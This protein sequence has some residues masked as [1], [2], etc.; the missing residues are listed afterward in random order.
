ML[1]NWLNGREAA[2]V[3]TALADEGLLEAGSD[4]RANGSPDGGRQRQALQSFLQRFLQKVDREARPLQLN[5]YKRAKLANTFKWR[6]L[7]KGIERPIVDELTQALVL[8]LTPVRAA[9]RSAQL[10]APSSAKAPP[11]GNI[12]TLLA[13][14]S[15]HM[16]RGAWARLFATLVAM[17][18]PRHSSVRPSRSI[19]S[20]P[21]GIPI[22]ARCCAGEAPL[23][24]QRRH[25]GAPSS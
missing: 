10:P 8:R 20:T 4:A 6:L 17:R 19:P 25:C 9:S 24:S 23:T 22:S 13:R 21:M 3:G 2:A 7:D 12:H 1:L 14:A 15:D 11:S 16:T 18:K 5:L